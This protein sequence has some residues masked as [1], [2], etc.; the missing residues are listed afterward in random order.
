M[1]GARGSCRIAD[2]AINGVD[3]LSPELGCLHCSRVRIFKVHMFIK[4]NGS[5]LRV[6]KDHKKCY[7]IWE[8]RTVLQSVELS[9]ISARNKL[10]PCN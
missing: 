3:I 8:Q 10:L 2:I 6:L 7:G 4:R 5:V 9:V 1:D